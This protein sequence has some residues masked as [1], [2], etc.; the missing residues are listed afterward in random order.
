MIRL[1]FP[2]LRGRFDQKKNQIAKPPQ[3]AT[4]AILRTAYFRWWL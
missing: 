4:A 1:C 3:E 2:P